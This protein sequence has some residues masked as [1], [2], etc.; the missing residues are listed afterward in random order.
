M[1][2]KKERKERFIAWRKIVDDKELF[3]VEIGKEDF[4]K[5]SFRIWVNPN[6]LIFSEKF[7]FGGHL[8]IP[9]ENVNILETDGKNLILKEGEYNL[10]NVYTECGY[11][12]QSE[13]E[14][15]SPA[16]AIYKYKTYKSE[17][18]SLG[19]SSGALVL[20]KE[21]FVKWKW[22]RDGRLYGLPAKGISIVDLSGY[23]EDLD[24]NIDKI[25]EL[26]SQ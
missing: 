18:G 10:F 1:S 11:R 4:G 16:V 20:T 6:L 9:K 7:E 15:I 3:Y 23:V 5:P 24:E 14:V 26:L 17:R 8:Y 2:E 12:G 25:K 19:I 22:K 13:I 21:S